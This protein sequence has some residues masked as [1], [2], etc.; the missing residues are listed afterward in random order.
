MDSSSLPEWQQA[1]A[2]FPR[3][4]PATLGPYRSTTQPFVLF[5]AY[6]FRSMEQELNLWGVEDHR[7]RSWAHFSVLFEAIQRVYRQWFWT[8]EDQRLRGG[9]C[10]WHN[11]VLVRTEGMECGKPNELK[12]FENSIRA[13]WTSALPT[14]Y[15]EAEFAKLDLLFGPAIKCETPDSTLETLNEAQDPAVSG[16]LLNSAVQ[17]FVQPSPD[18]LQHPNQGRLENG[19]NNSPGAQ[20]AAGGN[21][22]GIPIPQPQPRVSG[23]TNRASLHSMDPGYQ[24]HEVSP[25]NQANGTL[26]LPYPSPFVLGPHQYQQYQQQQY[27]QQQQAPLAPLLHQQ[28]QQLS[29]ATAPHQQQQQIFG[30]GNPLQNSVSG[31]QTMTIAGGVNILG[32]S[33]HFACGH[34]GQQYYIPDPFG[35]GADHQAST[36]TGLT[37]AAHHGVSTQQSYGLPPPQ[38]HP[39]P[40]TPTSTL[41]GLQPITHTQTQIPST[42]GRPKQGAYTLPPAWTKP[43]TQAEVEGKDYKEVKGLRAPSKKRKH[44]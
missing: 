29:F 9:I 10:L 42:P 44:G 15:W 36:G 6:I 35:T 28:Q 24:S 23:R 33:N 12:A 8:V 21:D 1:L 30:S 11:A 40:T 43:M 5:C 34:G 39:H 18:L 13:G 38:P 16:W 41:S 7:Q 27:Q 20:I 4:P 25:A 19:Q 17:Q 14:P 26:P 3:Q 32:G 37:A 2:Q 22:G 31:P